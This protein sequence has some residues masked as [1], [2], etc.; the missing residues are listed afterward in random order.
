[1]S[2]DQHPSEPEPTTRS[3]PAVPPGPLGIPGAEDLGGPLEDLLGVELGDALGSLFGGGGLGD[4][5]QQA[6]QVQNRLLE[7]QARAA[8]TEVHGSAGGGMVTVTASGD[9]QFRSIRIDPQVVDPD[10]IG[11]LED[12]VLAAVR[13]AVAAARRLMEV[14]PPEPGDGQSS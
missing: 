14:P 13:E 8:E 6:Q 11:M 10:D 2:D 4:L 5:L 9:L 3:V 7:A 1:V 12:L